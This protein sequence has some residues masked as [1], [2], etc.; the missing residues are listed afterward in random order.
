MVLGK[1]FRRCA[2]I[3]VA[4]DRLLF[5]GTALICSFLEIFMS[6]CSPRVLKK[7]FPPIVTGVHCFQL[8]IHGRL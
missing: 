8:C 7:I 6:F 3:P 2:F 5:I 1:L 4:H